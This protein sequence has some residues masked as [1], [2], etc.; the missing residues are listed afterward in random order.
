MI[1]IYHMFLFAISPKEDA[2]SGKLWPT[3]SDAAQFFHIVS[4]RSITSCAILDSVL[5]SDRDRCC[6]RRADAGD[7]DRRCVAISRLKVPGGRWV[8]NLRCSPISSRRRFLA[9]PMYRT[10]GNYGLSTITGR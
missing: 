6:G 7:R 2:F 1:P 4:I 5:E 8:M 9:V 3:A 10:M